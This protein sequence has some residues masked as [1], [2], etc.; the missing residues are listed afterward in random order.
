MVRP[1]VDNKE[2]TSSRARYADY[3]RKDNIAMPTPF[4][5]LS[6]LARKRSAVRQPGIA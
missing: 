1:G 5:A 3:Q 4:S 6:G 2:N